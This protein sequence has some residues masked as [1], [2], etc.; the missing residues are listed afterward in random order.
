MK[1]SVTDYDLIVKA[2]QGDHFSYTTLYLRYYRYSV[3]LVKTV[4]FS[5]SP[6]CISE[7][8]LVITCMEVFTVCLEF[9][10][11]EHNFFY[12]YWKR[13]ATHA[14]KKEMKDNYDYY[15]IH[16][17]SFDEE[18]YYGRSN[19]ELFGLLDEDIKTN[20]TAE[21]INKLIE[22]NQ[23]K[24]T[25]MERKVFIRRYKHGDSTLEVSRELNITI[26]SVNRHYKNAMAKFTAFIKEHY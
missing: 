20:I 12:P 21:E 23:V 14:I 5:N 13:S 6:V 25:R 7:E 8:E 2:R 26:S 18:S 10:T 24:F 16:D 19:H 9:Y 15:T 3:S 11:G 1:Y 4:V 17:T 22:S